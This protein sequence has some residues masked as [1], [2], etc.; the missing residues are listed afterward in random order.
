[1][2]T[3][4]SWSTGKDAAWALHLLRQRSDLEV[5]GL[6]TTFNEQDGLIGI[7]NVPVRL[8]RTQA[9]AVGLPLI[10]VPLPAACPDATY[11][12]RVRAALA[13]ARQSGVS[14]IAFGDLFLEDI[15]AFRE[16][17]LHG[18][19]V[20]SLFPLWGLG[21]R[22]LAGEMIAAGLE[23]TI[24]AVDEK[25]LPRGFVGRRFD[26]DLLRDLPEHVDPCGE[27]GEFHT[28]VTGGPMLRGAS[29]A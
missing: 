27:R 18:T 21:T 7:H 22:Q 23:A 26:L 8:A 5:V 6:I 19:G 4:I 16:D 11:R 3:L 10:E 12:A 17:V 9:E 25:Q 14:G 29:R 13:S 2:R 15:R 1:M 20:T 24:V 28:L